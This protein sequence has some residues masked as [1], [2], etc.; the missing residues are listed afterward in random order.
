MFAGWIGRFT[1]PRHIAK[2]WI[3]FF[4][5][6]YLVAKIRVCLT[7]KLR[8]GHSLILSF[9]TN[10][11]KSCLLCFLLIFC[12]IYANAMEIKHGQFFKYESQYTLRKLSL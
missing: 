4:P 2:I 11:Q 1:I 9:F 10:K 5:V 12:Q 8:N 7:H 6:F 3:A